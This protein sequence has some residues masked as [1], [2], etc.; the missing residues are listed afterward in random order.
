MQKIKTPPKHQPRSEHEVMLRCTGARQKRKEDGLLSPLEA[1]PLV[2]QA[3]CGF[4]WATSHAPPKEAPWLPKSTQQDGGGMYKPVG[5]WG[6]RRSPAAVAAWLRPLIWLVDLETSEL[7]Q[8]VL[9]PTRISVAPP[10]QVFDEAK[11][12][13][14][15]TPEKKFSPVRILSSIQ[16]RGTAVGID[17]TPKSHETA[18]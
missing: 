16:G 5:R 2:S 15:L 14:Q 3:A 8:L 9:L 18:D 7:P 12:H 6:R 17:V 10:P 4:R 1:T 11:L 13:L